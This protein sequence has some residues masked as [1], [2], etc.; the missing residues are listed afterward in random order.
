MSCS[1]G[2]YP[3][4]YISK[5]FFHPWSSLLKD[6]GLQAPFP[7]ALL[8]TRAPAPGCSPA[9]TTLPRGLR[10]ARWEC[11]RCLGGLH[12]PEAS[13]LGARNTPGRTDY[14]TQSPS[15]RT[16]GVR[17]VSGRADY[18]TQR[19]LRRALGARD[20]PGRDFRRL[21]CGGH[22]IAV[23]HGRACAGGRAWVGLRGDGRGPRPPGGSLAAS[24][25]SSG[26]GVRAG[27]LTAP[28][29]PDRAGRAAGGSP[30]E[31]GAASPAPGGARTLPPVLRPGR[32]GGSCC[33]CRPGP[34]ACVGGAAVRSGQ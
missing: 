22:L 15:R 33:A 25:A 30:G 16:P 28:R 12:Y 14:I 17:D 31:V 4:E 23:C 5:Y 9:R 29:R 21:P 32:R 1:F 2:D 10:A 20:V 11:G 24:E 7:K 19:P 26:T 13:A 8:G 6:L 18:I 27:T 3:R 34:G